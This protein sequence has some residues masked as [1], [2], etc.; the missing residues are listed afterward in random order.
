MVRE[1]ASTSMRHTNSLNF[2][3]IFPFSLGH[4][5]L[6]FSATEPISQPPLP[7][8]IQSIGMDVLRM[9]SFCVSPNVFASQILLFFADSV[10]LAKS[11]KG[12][13]RLLK[14]SFVG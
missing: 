9:G 5:T 13:E 2:I 7:N 3:D 12:F 14:G 11:L 1:H 10:K 8:A 6:C 4:G